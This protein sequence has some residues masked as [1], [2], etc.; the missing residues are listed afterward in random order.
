MCKS[1]EG[2]TSLFNTYWVRFPYGGQTFA[3]AV[4]NAQTLINAAKQAGVRRVIHIS[5]SNAS[6]EAHLPYYR[7][8]ALQE[9]ILANSGL[10]YAIIRPT[11]I[12]GE[13]DIL[14]N[15]IAWMLRRF[16]IFGVPGRGEYRLQP[17]SAEEVARIAVDADETRENAIVDAAGPEVFTFN[18]LVRLIA[19]AVGSRAMLVHVPASVA[20]VLVA[21]IGHAIGDVVLT[22]DEIKGLMANLLVSERAP[23]ERARLGPW[24]DENAGR[25]GVAYASE[26]ARHFQRAG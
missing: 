26:L 16:P 19:R 21:L 4:A 11:L 23:L 25:I 2:A 15:N 7:G 6:E 1:L 20:H 18:E 17:V 14:I 24:L 8:K 22:G 5:V 10:S 3:T 9:R 12:F 13:G